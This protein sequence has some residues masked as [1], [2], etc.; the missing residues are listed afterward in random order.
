MPGQSLEQVNGNALVGQVRQKSSAA[1]VAAGTFQA[2]SLVDQC[3]GLRQ[4]VGVETQLD[5]FLTRKKRVAAVHARG[6]RS[7]GLQFLL[8]FGA[9]KHSA[10]VAALGHVGQQA[11]LV[12]HQPVCG[13]DIAPAQSC[14][15]ANPQAR[16]VG[17]QHHRS[18]SRGVLAG[19]D[20][21]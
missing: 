15:L 2:R 4:A 6:L 18:V 1:A 8:Q 14:H 17:E 10:R 20:V 13:G 16:P 7:V 3:K 12:L 9:D 21:R 11:D 5:A 19:V